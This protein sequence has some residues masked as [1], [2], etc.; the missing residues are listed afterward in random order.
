MKLKLVGLSAGLKSCNFSVW[1]SFQIYPMTFRINT[2]AI[3]CLPL[4]LCSCPHLPPC[5]HFWVCFLWALGLPT[6]FFMLPQVWFCTNVL[7]VSYCKNLHFWQER[8][9]MWRKLFCC[10][11][12]RSKYFCCL[13]PLCVFRSFQ[14][15]S[16]VTQLVGS[17]DL[18]SVKI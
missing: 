11:Q 8:F 3:V 5:S 4:P 9:F 1:P 2:T 6:M 14:V 18:Y 10:C 15:Q 13:K 17:V 12:N 16:L 7:P